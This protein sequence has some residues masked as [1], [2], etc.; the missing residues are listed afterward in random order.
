MDGCLSIVCHQVKVFH[1]SGIRFRL[2]IIIII[3]TTYFSISEQLPVKRNGNTGVC[4]FVFFSWE[5]VCVFFFPIYDKNVFTFSKIFP[6]FAGSVF[7]KFFE[8]KGFSLKFW[9]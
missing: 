8:F 3:I 1:C 9:Q 6:S 2:L 5:K 7:S 4:L